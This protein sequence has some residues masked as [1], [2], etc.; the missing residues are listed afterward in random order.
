MGGGQ[1]LIYI[2]PIMRKNELPNKETNA[3]RLMD[4]RQK[5]LITAGS[6]LSK[7]YKQ[8][9]QFVVDTD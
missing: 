4:G 7:L 2:C 6:F 5:E 3:V 1:T 8:L 9:S